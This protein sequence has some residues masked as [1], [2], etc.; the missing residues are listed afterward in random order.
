M[1]LGQ[2]LREQV[3]ISFRQIDLNALDKL[4]GQ[5]IGDIHFYPDLTAAFYP[6]DDAYT[7]PF[8]YPIGRIHA[9]DVGFHLHPHYLNWEH[10]IIARND[11]TI[12]IEEAPTLYDFV[13]RHLLEKEAVF[14]EEEDDPAEDKA[15]LNWIEMANNAFG[16]DFYRPGRYGVFYSNTVGLYEFQPASQASLYAAAKT[17]ERYAGQGKVDL[18]VLNCAAALKNYR[19]T[20]VYS[21]LDQ[22][23][24]L[25]NQMMAQRPD[26][27]SDEMRRELTVDHQDKQMLT[28]WIMELVEAG[29][30]EWAL[31]V[32]IDFCQLHCSYNHPIAHQ[33]LLQLLE[34]TFGGR[35]V[36]KWIAYRQIE[37]NEAESLARWE[38]MLFELINF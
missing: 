34:G 9:E 21:D 12:L 8:F 32:L 30:Q 1:K 28:T 20:A 3:G 7:T 36:K 2:F 10:L 17:A 23:Y 31:K 11:H 14:Y 38:Q 19:Y 5:M 29:K 24:T 4:A 25:C 22:F 13:Y 37:P 16:A 15:F 27:F 26:K 33:L 18:A 35:L 6:Q